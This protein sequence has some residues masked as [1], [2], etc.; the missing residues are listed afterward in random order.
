[1]LIVNRAF[2]ACTKIEDDDQ[3]LTYWRILDVRYGA[4]QIPKKVNLNIYVTL[5][6]LKV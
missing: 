1:V 5:C 6:D 3:L 2:T 4:E